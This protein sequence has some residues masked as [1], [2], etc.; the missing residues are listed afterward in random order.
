MAKSVM[1]RDLPGGPREIKFADEISRHSL[2][3]KCRMLSMS[4]Y[5][6]PND[7]AF[8]EVCLHAQ[9]EQYGVY[10]IYCE[11]ER[12]NIDIEEMYQD[13]DLLTMLRDQFVE[14]P[15]K[16]TCGTDLQLAQLKTH[17]TACQPEVKCPT[18]GHD[19]R[20]SEWDAHTYTCAR[21][22]SKK[23]SPEQQD[24][25][26]PPSLSASNPDAP[27]FT[28]TK[29]FQKFPASVTDLS[30]RNKL[31]HAI[32]STPGVAQ[33]QQ[34]VSDERDLCLQNQTTKPEPS[35]RENKVSCPFCDGKVKSVNFNL[36][37]TKCPKSPVPCVHCG[38][39]VKKSD[40]MIHEH[41]CESNPQNQAKLVQI[42]QPQRP[43]SPPAVQRNQPRRSAKIHPKE[44]SK[45]NGKTNSWE[46]GRQPRPSYADAAR[47]DVGSV[48]KPSS[49]GQSP[50]QSERATKANQRERENGSAREPPKKERKR[51]SEEPGP[52][53]DERSAFA[54]P[55]Y[56]AQ[57]ADPAAS[58]SAFHGQSQS[59]EKE[60]VSCITLLKRALCCCCCC[61]DVAFGRE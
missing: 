60:N 54:S 34:A 49:S 48:S 21:A 2:C 14:C 53:P 45:E 11:Y 40:K 28:N 10:H 6:D 9:S 8:C 18:C 55:N 20:S 59:W 30:P 41:N 3:G 32:K 27:S 58:V 19:V 46:Q 50:P 43:P 38:Q 15:N 47:G 37:L 26:K 4:M 17:Y 1:Y 51:G 13:I 12:L 56:N 52:N 42:N 39:D 31:E 29:K 44:A 5:R 61:L 25:R 23:A 22:T 33:S 24:V 36:H 16:K 35:D 57:S 7:H